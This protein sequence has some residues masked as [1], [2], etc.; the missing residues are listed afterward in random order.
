MRHASLEMNVVKVFPKFDMYVMNS[1][2]EI[3][4]RKI[5][6]KKVNFYIILLYIILI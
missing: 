3:R 5:K 2:R 6:V 4:V 1:K